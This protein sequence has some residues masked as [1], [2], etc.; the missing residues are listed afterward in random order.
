MP[1]TTLDQARA[2]RDHYK[3]L[4]NST[5]EDGEEFRKRLLYQALC[6]ALN[7]IDSRTEGGDRFQVN[8]NEGC[9]LSRG[10]SPD[11]QLYRTNPD[12]VLKTDEEIPQGKNEVRFELEFVDGSTLKVFAVTLADIYRHP[13][14]CIF[15]KC[16]PVSKQQRR[17][18]TTQ[19][20]DVPGYYDGNLFMNHLCYASDIAITHTKSHGF[21]CIKLVVNR[22]VLDVKSVKEVRITP[23]N[24]VA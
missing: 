23:P 21:Q 10:S 3:H 16:L 19:V 9:D 20:F 17:D 6:V 8:L 12:V 18:Y 14:R 2:L 4:D 22:K 11:I 13:G 24:K 5:S 15:Y 1:I 7:D